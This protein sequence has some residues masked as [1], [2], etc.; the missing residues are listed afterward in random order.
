MISLSY[1]VCPGVTILHDLAEHLPTHPLLSTGGSL[2]LHVLLHDL[3]LLK[4]GLLLQHLHVPA[5]DARCQGCGVGVIVA[6]GRG[7][8]T[9]I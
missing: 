6:H 5:V 7:V 1:L 4:V 3:L 8:I 9:D 2:E